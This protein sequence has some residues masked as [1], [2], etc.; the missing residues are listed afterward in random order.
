MWASLVMKIKCNWFGD[1]C[2]GAW[3]LNVR[4]F[5][6]EDSGLENL[7]ER[8]AYLSMATLPAIS[9]ASAEYEDCFSVSGWR[10]GTVER[11]KCKVLQQIIPKKV[12]TLMLPKLYQCDSIFIRQPISSS[13]EERSGSET[14]I[15]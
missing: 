1:I 14:K 5:D 2:Q 6:D 11:Y 8:T 9:K 13:P 12:L 7:V 10:Q 15:R 3:N 4:N